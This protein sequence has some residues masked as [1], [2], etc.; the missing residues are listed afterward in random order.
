MGLSRRTFLHAVAIGAAVPATCRIVRAQSYPTRPITMIVP[1]PA[2]AATDAVGR[3]I[4]ESMRGS[5]G[6]PIVIENVTGANGSIAVGRVARAANDGYTITI[7]A[8]STFVANGVAYALA[9]NLLTDFEPIAPLTT[10]PILI[11]A[12]KAMPG[13]GLKGLI[14]WLKANPDKAT[15]GTN[16]VGSPQHV[17]AISFQNK[18][19]TRFGFVPYRGGAPALQDLLAGQIDLIFAPAGD[20]AGLVRAGSIKAYAVMAQNRIA[21]TPDLP[22]VDEG[23]M[24]GLYMSNWFGLWAPARTAKD[25]ISKLNTAAIKALAD[26]T[27]RTRL[28]DLGQQVFP[29]NQQTPEAL[30]AFHKAEIEKWWPILKAANIKGE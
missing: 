21:A 9:Y 20:A 24:P 29:P 6:Q 13:D 18:T 26:P 10:Q 4:G 11:V 14:A 30:D 7:G 15:A 17:A 28:A 22:T 1:F 2:G 5:L 27:V 23:G 16:G 3:L 19:G 12:K 25:V 8:W